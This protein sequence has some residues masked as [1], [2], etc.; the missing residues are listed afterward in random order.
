MSDLSLKTNE[1]KELNIY[2]YGSTDTSSKLMATY[3]KR[4]ESCT[5]TC[6]KTKKKLET[7]L[8]LHGDE[9]IKKSRIHTS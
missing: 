7:K 6:L 5:F 9:K 1:I 2:M 4:T 8:T 3:R